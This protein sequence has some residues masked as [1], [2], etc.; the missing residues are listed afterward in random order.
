MGVDDEIRDVV[1]R[2]ENGESRELSIYGDMARLYHYLF[3]K[4]YDYSGQADAATGRAPEKVGK[5]V[6]GGCGTGGLTKLLAE[7]YP[8]AEVTGVDLNSPMLDVAGDE[9]SRENIE[10]RQENLLDLEENADIYTVFGTVNHF[11][12]DEIKTLFQNI[13]DS[14]SSGG[15]LTFD[16]KS[17][18]SEKHQDG[19]V[20]HWSTETEEF[21][22]ENPVMTVYDDGQAYYS[23]SFCFREKETQKE[24]YTGELMEIELYTREEI[25]EMLKDAGFSEEEIEFRDEG[26]QRGVFVAKKNR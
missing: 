2:I 5:I 12:E 10:Y 16:F 21:E 19:Y 26:A 24:F 22:V 20:N 25:R 3:G 18:E 4:E 1:E 9:N 13:F 8:E 7:R 6:D 14:L 11:R 15:V 23:F 17:P